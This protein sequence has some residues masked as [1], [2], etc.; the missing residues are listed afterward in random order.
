MA[1]EALVSVWG[2]ATA[3]AAR[4]SIDAWKDE[5]YLSRGQLWSLW[6]F[7]EY[8]ENLA[9][10]GGWSVDGHSWK[11]RSPLG[12]LVVKATFENA[13]VVCFTSA[14]TFLNAVCVFVRKA[15]ESRVEWVRDRYR[16]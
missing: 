10:A 12:I 13:P 4:E 14:R 9:T 3:I 1:E 11:E 16:V 7:T 8:L 15:S 2:T 6:L 5:R